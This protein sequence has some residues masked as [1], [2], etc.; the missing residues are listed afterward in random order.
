VSKISTDTIN[1]PLISRT[2]RIIILLLSAL[3]ALS[4]VPP[5]CAFGQDSLAAV[6]SQTQPKIVKIFCA[7]G[8]RGSEPYQSGFLISAEVHTLTAW[9]YVLDSDVIT[10][11]LHDGRKLTAEVIGMDP[12]SEIAVIKID[13][14]GLPHFN[15][16]EAQSLSP[17]AKILA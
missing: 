1:E 4:A 2:T 15:L 13:S 3:F 8:L 11:Y 7:R 12:R 10:V 17:G 6:A 5:R 9:S 14:P 16:D